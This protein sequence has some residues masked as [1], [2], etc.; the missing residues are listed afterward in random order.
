M[1]ENLLNNKFELHYYFSED[2]KSHSMDA[3][4][5]NKCEHELL[6][7][8]G[9]I[10]KELEINLKVETEA[11]KE[12]G[13]TE[14]WTLLNT[15]NLQLTIVISLLTLALSR[16][17]LRKTKLEKRDLE[18]SIEER[19]LNIEL[20]KKELE[21]KGIPEN[22]VNIEKF[23]L[24]LNNNYKIIKHKSN[25]YKQL[26]KYPKVKKI[27]TTK[28]NQNKEKIEEPI[29]VERKD[30]DKFILESDNL[31]TVPDENA[32]IEIISP[33]LK[34]GRF[35]WKGVYD[36]LGTVIDFNMKDKDFKEHVVT[37]GVPFKNGTFIDCI[38]EVERKI[39]DFG[40]V[41]NSNYSVL[42]V[43]KQH[44]ESTSFETPQ[45]KKYKKQKELLRTQL[46]LFNQNN[47]PE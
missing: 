15:D 7:I 10:T 47:Y 27:S 11:Y 42:T 32:T 36:K 41:F 19:N 30:F 40:N 43:L 25:F 34:N 33:V 1:T 4:T 29:F 46:D 6:Q 17:P 23:I 8:V 31:E 13:L 38:L 39:D 5:R 45:G 24:I 44:D 26:Y 12:G 22:K 37:D 16:V 14:L 3:F 21:S 35:K 20:L 18:L 28:L 2:D 9:E